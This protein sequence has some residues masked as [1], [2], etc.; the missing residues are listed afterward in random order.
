[1]VRLTEKVL[2]GIKCVS[3]FLSASFVRNMFLSDNIFS[4]LQMGA[5]TCECVHVKCRLFLLDFNKNCNLATNFSRTVQYQI[6]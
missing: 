1:M 5:K 3:H 6:S 4:E 2:L